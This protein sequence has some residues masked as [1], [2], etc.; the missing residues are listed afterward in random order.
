MYANKRLEGST[1]SSHDYIK[2]ASQFERTNI[3]FAKSA[4][5]K[6]LRLLKKH[7]NQI[8]EFQILIK[9][10]SLEHNQDNH[11]ASQE[12]LDKA[13][14]LRDFVNHQLIGGITG[15]PDSSLNFNLLLADVKLFQLEAMLMHSQNKYDE[16]IN[17]LEEALSLVENTGNNPALLHRIFHMQGDMYFDAKQ[18]RLAL[19]SYLLAQHHAYTHP[20]EENIKLWDDIAFIYTRLN[21]N[22]SAIKYYKKALKALVHD[23]LL[24]HEERLRLD[25]PHQVRVLLDISRSY[26]KAGAFK[27]ALDFG[28]KALAEAKETKNEEFTLKSLTHLSIIY[29]RLSSYENALEHG[30][31]A[32]QIYQKNKNLNGLA[33]SFNAIGLIYN[34]LGNRGKAKNYFNKV[35]KLPKEKV[36]RKYYAAALRELAKFNFYQQSYDQALALN[37]QA[38]QIYEET[39]NLKGMATVKRNVGHIY[40]ASGQ[41]K[42]AIKAFTFAF[43]TSK[44]TGDAWE[45]ATNLANIALLYA[46]IQPEDTQYWAGK[47]LRIAKRVQAKPVMQ[48]AYMA[49]TIAEEKMKNFQQALVYAKLQAD[50]LN[51][52][53]VDTI[54]THTNE[55]SALQNVI[56]KMYEIEI[57]KEKMAEIS[58]K[59]FEQND[60][61]TELKN[62][63]E[64]DETQIQGMQIIILILLSF[65][66]LFI[67]KVNKATKV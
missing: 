52:I 39:N 16:A 11:I 5:L 60:T 38:Y 48:K 8:L 1:R 25:F 43:E 40:Q 50:T 15:K 51:E 59:F 46:E 20:N 67:A 26:K 31:E 35:L 17:R 36:K 12:Y 65:I 9:L 53:K 18:Y 56:N 14:S 58:D 42:L 24:P 2:L 66:L 49:L 13:Q 3:E 47:S 41:D 19:T 34:R 10:A 28:N 7:P 45:Q 54:S 27:E 23:N 57:L 6:S 21:D 32:L 22:Y 61:L 4:L 29:R 30:I 37:K 64:S 33:S 44:K 63:S 62:K 55:M